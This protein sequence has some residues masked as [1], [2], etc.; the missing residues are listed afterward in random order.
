MYKHEALS[1]AFTD[2]VGAITNLQ[3]NTKIKKQNEREE[4]TKQNRTK[5][6]KS[7]TGG[8]C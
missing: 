7:L 5:L 8:Q 2:V 6:P 3:K 1:V 4:K